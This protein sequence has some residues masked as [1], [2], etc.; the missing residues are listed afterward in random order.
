MG[1]KDILSGARKNTIPRIM[2][3]IAGIGEVIVHPI[4]R[5]L[6]CY[7]CANFR[8]DGLQVRRE[9]GRVWIWVLSR[10]IVHLS[11]ARH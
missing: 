3:P 9:G 7:F 11:R 6:P 4:V 10:D 8:S 2:H 1:V 5:L